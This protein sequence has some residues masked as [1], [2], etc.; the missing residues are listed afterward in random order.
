M[1]VDLKLGRAG[2]GP[3]AWLGQSG[4]ETQ[5]HGQGPAFLNQALPMDLRPMDVTT[6]VILPPVKHE[7]QLCSGHQAGCCGG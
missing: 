6:L 5:E 2:E 1:M 3:S 4:F 7:H